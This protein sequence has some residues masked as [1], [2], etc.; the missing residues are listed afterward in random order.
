MNQAEAEA[1]GFGDTRAGST[2]RNIQERRDRAVPFTKQEGENFPAGKLK[3]SLPNDQV[4][5]VTPSGP[6]PLQES[7]EADK[8]R[9]GVIQKGKATRSSP[10]DY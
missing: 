3:P 10:G 7:D 5:R 6:K 8:V 9:S 4:S 1:M 2:G